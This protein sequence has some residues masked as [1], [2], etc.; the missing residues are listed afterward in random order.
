MPAPTLGYAAP[1]SGPPGT[2]ITLKGTGFVAGAQ[3]A[4]PN[5]TAATFVDAETLTVTV[6]ATLV[7]PGGGT[8]AI[9]IYVRNPDTL[10]SNRIQWLVEFAEKMPLGFTTIA[11]VAGEVPGFK[12][13]GTRI[14]DAQLESWVGTVGQAIAG[15][16]LRRGLS[17]KPSD[18]QQAESST[19]MPEASAVLEMINRVGAAAMLAAAIGGQMG[20]A[21]EWNLARTL[22]RRYQDEMKRLESGAYDRLFKPG[23]TTLE[24]GTQVSGGDI[25]T[26]DGNAEQAFSKTQVF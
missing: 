7:G 6:D 25:E 14:T 20:G 3:A 8:R 24:T 16:M 9:D 12:S 23:A 11:R 19:A 1:P 10:E 2:A 26:D 18:W 15:A 22:E 21:Q 17:L 5:L 13:G 4:V